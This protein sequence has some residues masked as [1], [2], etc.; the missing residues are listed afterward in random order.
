VKGA[1]AA[2]A[3][4]RR[5]PSQDRGQQRVER[6]L[7]AAA[8]VIAEVG[9]DA[10]T[11]NAIAARARTSVGS[12]YQFF[13]HKQAIVQALAVRY[14]EA[15][16]AL[17]EDTFQEADPGLPL[18]ALLDAT[19]LRMAAFHRAHP[20]YG[21]VYAASERPGAPGG[22]A[23]LKASIVARVG[24]LIHARN[25]ALPADEVRI[26]ARVICELV[27]ALAGEAAR[28]APADRP[29]LLRELR[30][31]LLRYVEPMEPM[32]PGAKHGPSA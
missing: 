8:E 30:A 5:V 6:I 15:L 7:D 3:P 12:L 4:L 32:E 16:D 26:Y 28:A 31:V 22:W 19:A 21:H 1:G 20:A 14:G 27:H 11:T 17:G 10:A 2:G 25:P 23:G 24:A 29:R 18:P 9:V 13:P